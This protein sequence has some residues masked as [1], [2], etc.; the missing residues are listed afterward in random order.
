MRVLLVGTGDLVAPVAAE[1]EREL[2]DVATVVV[3]L[4]EAAQHGGS[5]AQAFVIRRSLARPWAVFRV[6]KIFTLIICIPYV[7]CMDS[8]VATW[9]RLGPCAPA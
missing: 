4:A 6:T 3:T 2:P 5:I 9:L 1:I 8:F 7:N